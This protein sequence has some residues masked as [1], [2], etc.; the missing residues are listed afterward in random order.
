MRPVRGLT[1]LAALVATALSVPSGASAGVFGRAPLAAPALAGT[2]P[3]GFTETTQWSGLGNPTVIRFAPDGR[4]FVAAKSG[5]V[6]VF[7]NLDDPTPSVYADLRT[8]VDD[9]WDRGLLGLAIDSQNRVF[10]LYTYDKAPGS[11]TVPRW[12]DACP[13][14][15]GP[16]DDGCVVSGP[17][18]RL[19]TARAGPVLVAGWG[20]Q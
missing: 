19:S 18:S 1:I 6:Y 16:T 7:D 20:Q 14:P 13:S 15:P 10:V 17:L 8:K 2:L 9:Y 5:L 12:S 4:V 11:S 3:L